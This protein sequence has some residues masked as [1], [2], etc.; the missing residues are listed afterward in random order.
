MVVLSSRLVPAMAIVVGCSVAETPTDR[1]APAGAGLG[2]WGAVT[3]GARASVEP[4][5]RSGPLVARTL[6]TYTNTGSQPV[7]LQ[8]P[9]GCR[10]SLRA[11]QVNGDRSWDQA[12]WRAVSLE[13]TGFAVACSDTALGARLAPNG[14]MVATSRE[15]P[16]VNDILGDSLP[17]GEYDI[18]V[19]VLPPLGAPARVILAAGRVRLSRR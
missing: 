2:R 14:Q 12:R 8:L 6:L 19:D 7:E 16:M 10:V 17:E 3:Y 18:S 11:K 13:T 4:F 9:A 1:E 5:E 15:A